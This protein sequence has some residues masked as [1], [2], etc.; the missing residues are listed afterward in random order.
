MEIKSLGLRH[1][2]MLHQRKAEGSESLVR[3]T[4]RKHLDL[5][6]KKDEVDKQLH[7]SKMYVETK[8]SECNRLVKEHATEQRSL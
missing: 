7:V 8:H 5:K 6:D 3:E 2:A 1:E 4:H